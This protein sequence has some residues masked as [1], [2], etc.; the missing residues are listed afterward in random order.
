MT[1]LILAAYD[2]PYSYCAYE[3]DGTKSVVVEMDESDFRILRDIFYFKEK[4][5]ILLTEEEYEEKNTFAQAVFNEYDEIIYT[6]D[7]DVE[8]IKPRCKAD[9]S[10]QLSIEKGDKNE[11]M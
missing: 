4:P 1:T 6:E 2:Y 3:Y 7:A 10:Q 8:I 5:G 11:N 9:A